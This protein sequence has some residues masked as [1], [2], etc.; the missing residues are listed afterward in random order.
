MTSS[1]CLRK[2]ARAASASVRSVNYSLV[3]GDRTKTPLCF[4]QTSSKRPII[5]PVQGGP[6]GVKAIPKLAIIHPARAGAKEG[7]VK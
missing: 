3:V 7:V 1:A 6:R 2:S 4:P 5:P